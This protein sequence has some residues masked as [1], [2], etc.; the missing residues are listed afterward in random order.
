MYVRGR[1]RRRNRHIMCAH[2]QKRDAMKTNQYQHARF[3]GERE[4]ATTNRH[5]M[6]VRLIAAAS[7]LSYN[8]IASCYDTVSFVAC[9]FTE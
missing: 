4:G 1:S 6:P 9:L 3:A 5:F 7:G 2:G 8:S